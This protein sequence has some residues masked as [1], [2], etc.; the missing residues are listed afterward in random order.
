MVLSVHIKHSLV[1]FN[2]P[3]FPHPPPNHP[4]IP[5]WHKVRNIFQNSSESM[6]VQIQKRLR[7]SYLWLSDFFVACQGRCFS[8]W[9]LHAWVRHEKGTEPVDLQI[10]FMIN[11]SKHENGKIWTEAIF[12]DHWC[13]TVHKWKPWCSICRSKSNYLLW[14]AKTLDHVSQ[15]LITQRSNNHQHLLSS[16]WYYNPWTGLMCI[17]T[18]PLLLFSSAVFGSIRLW[19]LGRDCKLCVQTP[20]DM[21]V[22]ILTMVKETMK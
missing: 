22:V 19:Q 3:P 9:L 5:I 7:F 13:C 20:P 17:N 18:T 16:L 2:I 11:P 10:N 15:P 14:P 1:H 4:T 21:A 12:P 8:K 6:P